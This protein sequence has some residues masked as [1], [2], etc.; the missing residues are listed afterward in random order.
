MSELGP[1]LTREQT[2]TVTRSMTAAAIFEEFPSEVH[3]MPAVWSTPDM[4][5]KME[6]VCA[7]TVAPVLPE[8]QMTVGF[9]NEVSHLGGTPVGMT[10]RVT[11]ALTAVEGRKLTFAVEAFDEKEKVGE[12]IHIRYIVDRAKF[13][14]RLAAKS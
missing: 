5:S 12:G 3:G 8:G 9:R 4:I 10:V 2:F 7:A 6:V 14:S 13:L 11:A 1:G